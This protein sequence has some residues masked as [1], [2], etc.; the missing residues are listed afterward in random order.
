MDSLRS[1]RRR[2]RRGGGSLTPALLGGRR[3]S[4]R[5]RR[6]GSVNY[7]LQ[8]A[9][10]GSLSPN[11]DPNIQYNGIAGQ[12]MGQGGV[13]ATALTAGGYRRSRRSRRDRR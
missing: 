5:S 9:S 4:R 3:R 7:A 6:G 1:R 13:T 2:S 10:V 11:A 12:G 8:P